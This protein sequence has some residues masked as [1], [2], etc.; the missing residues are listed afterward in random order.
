MYV[1]IYNV[2]D[3]RKVVVVLYPFFANKYFKVVGSFNTINVYTQV[4]PRK[5]TVRGRDMHTDLSLLVV[6]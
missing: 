6:R 1:Q 5:N 3:V 2:D 4:R